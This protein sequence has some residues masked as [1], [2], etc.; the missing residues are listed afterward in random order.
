MKDVELSNIDDMVKSAI[1]I[2][3]LILKKKI[4]IKKYYQARKIHDAIGNDMINDI[5]NGKIP[6]Q[7]YFEQIK[8][9]IFY[10]TKIDEFILDIENTND[11]NILLELFMYRNISKILSVTEIYI[12]NKKYKNSDKIK[13][14]YSMRN[15]IVGLFE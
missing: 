4:H 11:L 7:D 5:L 3:D 12:K 6:T 10:E 9:N 14:L 13:M 15:S 8:E 1:G 2:H